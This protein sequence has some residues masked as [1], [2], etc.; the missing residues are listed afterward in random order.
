LHAPLA[1]AADP[2]KIPQVIPRLPMQRNIIASHCLSLVLV[3]TRS[4]LH[5]N[6]QS[7]ARR[8]LIHWLCGM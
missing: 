6:S 5:R 3:S 7:L 2:K 8:L 1:Y 4:L